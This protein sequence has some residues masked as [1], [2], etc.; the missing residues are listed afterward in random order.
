MLLGFPS[1][2]DETPP[3][4]TASIMDAGNSSGYWTFSILDIDR[5]NVRITDCMVR[6]TVG[7]ASSPPVEI[8][9]GGKME[10]Q[11]SFGNATGYSMSIKDVGIIGYISP[12]DEF[13]IG[14]INN[15]TGKNTYQPAG[16]EITL[17]IVY[18][19]TGGAIVTKSFTL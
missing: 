18:W 14:P 16:T 13:M 15:E 6:V 1:H 17:Q 9:P 4:P 3:T 5:N 2:N 10:I 7:S 19:V 12:G 11:V 8:P